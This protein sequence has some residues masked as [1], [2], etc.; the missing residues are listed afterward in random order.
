MENQDTGLLLSKQNIQLYRA[1]FKQFVALHGIKVLHRAPRPGKTYNGYGELETFYFEPEEVGCIFDEHPNQKSMKKMGWNAELQD[2]P[3]VLHVPYDLK[4]LQAGSLFIIPSGL[5][6]APPRI[7][8]VIQLSN[9]AVYPASISCE[10]GTEW[11]NNSP[12]SETV[13]F[14]KSNFN[15]LADPEEADGYNR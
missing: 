8:R 13:D 9:I 14:S 1:W 3:I 2:N 11:H 12:K 6:N 4:G 10:L 15:L 7:F 5:D